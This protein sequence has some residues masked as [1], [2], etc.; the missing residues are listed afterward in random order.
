MQEIEGDAASGGLKVITYADLMK[1][2][3]DGVEIVPNDSANSLLIKIQSEKH[4]LN[5]SA[6]DLDLIKKWIDAGALEK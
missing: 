3:K 6:A 4:F 1:G 5:L 2:G